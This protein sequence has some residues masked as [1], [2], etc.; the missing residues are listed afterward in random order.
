MTVV[1]IVHDTNISED[2]VI[3]TTFAA[4]EKLRKG[5][6]VSVFSGGIVKKSIAY[7]TDINLPSCGIVHLDANSGQNVIVTQIGKENTYYD[8]SGNPG[9]VCYISE[10]TTGKITGIAPVTTSSMIQ[11][12][13]I[14]V[15]ASTVLV[16]PVLYLRRV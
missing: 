11:E 1:G 15:N 10:T 16:N 6:A 8:L 13:G 9:S 14:I 2:L 12:M 4:G 3:K 7:Y 5:D